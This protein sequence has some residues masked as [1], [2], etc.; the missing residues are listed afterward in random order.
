M[1]DKGIFISLKWKMTLLISVIF[2]LLHSMFSYLIYLDSSENLT[3]NRENIQTRNRQIARALID[4]SFLVLEQFTESVSVIETEDDRRSALFSQISATLDK[5]WQQWQFNWGL[6]SAVLYNQ[7]GV[8]LKQWG[9]ALKPNSETVMSVLINESPNHQ[10]LCSHAC[11]QFVLIP[12]MVNS[13]IIGTFGVSRSLAD[14]I[15]RYQRATDSD[16]GILI[17]DK[18]FSTDG[19]S[20][21]L[22]TLTH[23]ELNH[24]IIKQ[25]Q[26]SYFFG[27]LL[28]KTKHIL[29]KD[30]TFEINVFAINA[31]QESIG[32]PFFIVIDDISDELQTIKSQTQLIWLYGVASLALALLCLLIVVVFSL[33]RVTRLSAAL[34]LLAEQRYDCFRRLLVNSTEFSSGYDELDI[35]NR[36]ALQLS[37]HLESLEENIKS[38]M[39]Q[40]L[41]QGQELTNERDFVQ[42]L[43]NVAP[44][45]VLTQDSNGRVLSI[46][47]AGIDSF[48][49]NKSLII[50]NGFDFFIPEGE[51]NHI[52][53]LNRMRQGERTED[54]II[55]GVLLVNAD[56]NCHVSW[57]HSAINP[58]GNQKELIILSLAV[59]ISVR[60]TK[61]SQCEIW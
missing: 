48:L 23:A 52:A 57:I 15:I 6:E 4:D 35:L 20:Y 18:Q 36:M 30:K 19:G 53:Q 1:N 12:V 45:V 24:A 43:I 38:S 28:G 31:D 34:P 14:T 56:E 21:K 2:L 5:N 7:K 3:R 16:I 9:D 32:A 37:E 29:I 42:H 55:D 58:Q 50:G 25:L 41:E 46:N 17:D 10:I 44:I 8:L 51:V 59:D 33:R 40:L 26:K 11:F 49:M 27:D 22:S 39:Q 13:Q 60:N 47:Q 54:L 61:N